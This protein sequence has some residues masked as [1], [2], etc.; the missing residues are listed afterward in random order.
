MRLARDG[1]VGLCAG[2][3]GWGDVRNTTLGFA[4]YGYLLPGPDFGSAHTNPWLSL[5]KNLDPYEDQSNES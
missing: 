4:R 1:R 5:L 3:V 2:H